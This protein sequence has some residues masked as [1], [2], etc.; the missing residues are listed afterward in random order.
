MSRGKRP[1]EL[2]LCGTV[3]SYVAVLVRRAVAQL[4]LQEGKRLLH[5]VDPRGGGVRVQV[6]PTRGLGLRLACHL[7][8]LVLPLQ[9][10]RGLCH[11][12]IFLQVFAPFIMRVFK[13][14]LTAISGTKWPSMEEPLNGRT[15]PSFE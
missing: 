13:R 14:V 6:C 7:P 9:T 12:C 10:G 3:G 2:E 1:L 8:P 15:A 5:P 11:S 4:H